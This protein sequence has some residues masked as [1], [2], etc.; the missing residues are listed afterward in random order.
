MKKQLVLFSALTLAS[1]FTFAQG[2]PNVF[3]AGQPARAADVNANFQS[4]V[5][6]IDATIADIATNEAN[7]AANASAIAA[8]DL[9]GIQANAN[10]IA[11]IDTSGIQANANAIAAID[12]SGIQANANAIAAIDTS[13]IQVNADAIAA[14]DT[15]GIQANADAVSNNT[16]DIVA[17]ETALIGLTSRVST[18]ENDTTVSAIDTRVTTIE[19]TIRPN[20]DYQGFSMP[21]S[22]PGQDRNFIVLRDNEGVDGDGYIETGYY[23]RMRYENSDGESISVNG[24]EQVFPYLVVYVNVFVSEETGSVTQVSAFI[25]GMD[26][27]NYHSW[28]GVNIYYDPITLD[29]TPSTGRGSQYVDTYYGEGPTRAISRQW[30]I[31]DDNF[32]QIISEL[33][34]RHYTLSSGYQANGIDFGD[35]PIRI[36]HR[37]E[38]GSRIRVQGIGTVE[39]FDK[40]LPG[41]KV[42]Y[43]N[44]NG[45]TGGDLSGTPFESGSAIRDLFF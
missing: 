26:D 21:F 15:N 3:S 24:V 4:V 32:S 10:A 35:T 31:Y 43:Y 20:S 37:S 11:A 29:P 22:A 27:P 28:S 45:Q 34:S 18:L 7:I 17:N 38:G 42:I 40:G 36:E 1:S 19:S 12:T 41:R 5:E 16:D 44:V 39:R 25:D 9:S 2:V 23:L 33:H 6:L 8:I 14:I 30:T 13:G